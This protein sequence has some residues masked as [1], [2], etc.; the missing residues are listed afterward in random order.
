MKSLNQVEGVEGAERDV[1]FAPSAASV[2]KNNHEFTHCRYQP[3]G[4]PDT[5]MPAPTH[6]RSGGTLLGV[7]PLADF[8]FFEDLELLETRKNQ[9]LWAPWHPSR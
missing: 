5:M 7:R 2:F 8:G 1:L 3:P 6:P 9:N 4:S